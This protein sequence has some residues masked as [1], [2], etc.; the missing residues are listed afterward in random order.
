MESMP[1]KFNRNAINHE[2]KSFKASFYKSNTKH[3]K[4]ESPKIWW[5]VRSLYAFNS[6]SGT[7]LVTSILKELKILRTRILEMQS[8]RPFLSLLKNITCTNCSV[9]YC[10]TSMRTGLLLRA[11]LEKQKFPLKEFGIIIEDSITGNEDIP[12]ELTYNYNSS[13]SHFE[14]TTSNNNIHS[15]RKIPRK[16][17]SQDYT[18]RLHNC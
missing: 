6:N 5:K 13:Y 3:M 2:R 9:L 10:I 11:G 7:F 18:E 12:N 4:E 1:L 16:I 15:P 17:A 8:T 14:T